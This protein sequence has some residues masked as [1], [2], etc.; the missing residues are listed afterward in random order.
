MGGNG[1]KGGGKY[2]VR[3]VGRHRVVLTADT[4]RGLVESLWGYLSAADKDEL[5]AKFNPP[6][7]ASWPDAGDDPASFEWMQD[8][9]GEG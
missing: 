5:L 2:A 4:L 7:R 9:G 8:I 3:D 1:I 6:N